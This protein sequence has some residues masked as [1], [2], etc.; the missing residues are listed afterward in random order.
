M[1]VSLITY[2]SVNVINSKTNKVN[3]NV[4]FCGMKS[5]TK[6]SAGNIGM[7]CLVI[8]TL[9]AA[10]FIK[11]FRTI[12]ELIA[13]PGNDVI[14]DEICYNIEDSFKHTDYHLKSRP[15][16]EEAKEKLIRILDK[17]TKNE[18]YADFIKNEAL[19]FLS[20][21]FEQEVLFPKEK[22][23]GLHHFCTAIKVIAEAAVSKN[24]QEEKRKI[25]NDMITNAKRLMQQ[26]DKK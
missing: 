17:H 16:F 19:E 26:N 18:E 15:M 8:G 20:E 5:L 2:N 24:L 6:N 21:N 23:R 9:I 13:K 3:N 12:F 25:A 7:G 1:N 22:E 10:P 14:I 4:S 11:L